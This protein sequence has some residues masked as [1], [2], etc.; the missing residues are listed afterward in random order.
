ML[1]DLLCALSRFVRIVGAFGGEIALT[2][3]EFAMIGG[4]RGEC[5]ECWYAVREVMVRGGLDEH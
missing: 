4:F 2:W 1:G 3:P 5:E